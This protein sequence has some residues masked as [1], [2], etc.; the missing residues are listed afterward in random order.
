MLRLEN[1]QKEYVTGA[2]KVMALNGVSITLRKNEF[3]S[4]LGPSGCG[5]TTLLNIIGGLD[6]CTAGDMFVNG[7]SIKKFSDREMDS[8]RNHVIGFVFQS[9]NLIPHQTV[10]ANVELALTL[11][12]ISKAGRRKK[13]LEALK[14]VGLEEQADKRP[15]QLSGGQMQ[16]VAIARALVND[17]DILLADEPTGALDSETGLQVMDLLSEIARDRLVIMVTHNPELA[18][19]Y[20]TR[21]VRLRDGRVIDDSNPCT[22]EETDETGVDT[23]RTGMGLFSALGLSLSNLLT[24][25]T[26][27]ILIAFAGSI[28]IIGIALIL[29]MSSGVQNYIDRIERET[30]SSYPIMLTGE[31]MDMTGLME[32]MTGAAEEEEELEDGYVYSGTVMRELVNMMLGEVVENDLGAFKRHIDNDEDFKALTSGVSYV[33]PSTLHIWS[34]AGEK[35]LQV[36]PST[37]M[38]DMM[39]GASG[40]DMPEYMNQLSMMSSMTDTGAYKMSVFTELFNNRDLLDSQYDVVAGRWPEEI[41]EVVLI[42]G[43]KGKV[44]DYTLYSLGLLPREELNTL[45]ANAVLGVDAEYTSTRWS[46]DDILNLSF[47]MVLPTDYFVN[48]GSGVWK[49]IRGDEAAFNELL[50]N[51]MEIKVVGIVRPAEGSIVSASSGTLGYLSGLT[52]YVITAVNDSEIVKQQLADPET[53]V[54]EGLPFE[55]TAFDIDM[56]DLNQY[57]DMVGMVEKLMGKER[58]NE[59]IQSVVPTLGSSS[60]YAENLITLGVCSLEK[61]DAINIYPKD[62]ESK[63]R[64]QEYISAYNEENKDKALSYTDYVGLLLT[65]VTDIVNAVTYV[66][67]GFVAVSLIVSSIMIGVITYISVLERTKEIGI[68][69]AMG[70]SKRDISRVFNAETIIIG[71]TAGLL[72]VGITYLLLLPINSILYSL[73]D[74]RGIAILPVGSACTLVLI[75]VMLTLIAGIIPS[76]FAAKRD[77]VAALRSE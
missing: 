38:D 11:T 23:H 77:P 37:A 53:D 67:V 34:T 3:V 10:A 72:G 39:A 61:P 46:Y 25:K 32:S 51:A 66:L 35:P 19:Q 21:I 47:R 73:T 12:G 40:E 13:A 4:I 17:P 45:L 62:F 28:G 5:K 60:S 42:T 65:S 63:D 44:N 7:K 33:Y 8:Y 15:M 48:N 30:L 16:R 9:Y 31:N 49:D 22:E 68:L 20:S 74:I 54:F 71:L 1:I 55:E 29:A 18:Q 41:N 26:R 75:S 24:K 27:T 36:N 69:R 76:R 70:A 6:R 2:Q 52:D 56:M 59:I 14:K 43:K 58:M 57:A 64:I 50:N